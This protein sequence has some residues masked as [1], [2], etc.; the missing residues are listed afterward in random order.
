MHLAR[1][2]TRVAL[3]LVPLPIPLP[4][5]LDLK[6]KAPA[7]RKQ[8]DT[9]AFRILF[10]LLRSQLC[11]RSNS[12]LVLALHLLEIV[13][14]A[15]KPRPAPAATAVATELPPVQEGEEE[16]AP[17][18]APAAPPADTNMDGKPFFTSLLLNLSISSCP[19]QS[20]F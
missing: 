2:K 18:P 14:S 1:Y 8:Q 17:S 5:V 4:F 7:N 9:P 20:E 13:L 15:S 10:T 19:L 6:G 16:G 3:E 12:H 11:Q